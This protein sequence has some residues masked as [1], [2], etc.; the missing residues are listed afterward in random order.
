MVA[1]APV[2]PE[3]RRRRS[4]LGE[5]QVALWAGRRERGIRI[6]TGTATAAVTIVR[7]TLRRL[8]AAAE[9]HR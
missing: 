1:K 2:I 5:R 4:R 6:A 3:P 9:D 8:P 7:V